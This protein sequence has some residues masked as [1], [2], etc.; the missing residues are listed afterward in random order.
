MEK[1]MPEEMS[2]EELVE[3][4]DKDATRIGLT[5]A[6][7]YRTVTMAMASLPDMELHTETICLSVDDRGITVH[8]GNPHRGSCKHDDFD[9][10]DNQDDFDDEEGMIYDEL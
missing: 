7:L 6:E 10:N 3:A 4:M 1:K 9:D 2:I 8:V 5:I